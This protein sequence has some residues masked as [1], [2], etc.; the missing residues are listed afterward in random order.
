MH[1]KTRTHTRG[2]GKASNLEE[3][4]S[5]RDP[6]TIGFLF[7]L[8]FVVILL[9]WLTRYLVEKKMEKNFQETLDGILKD[10]I[11][12]YLIVTSIRC[13]HWI[14]ALDNLEYYVNIHAITLGFLLFAISWLV[15]GVYNVFTNHSAVKKW[16]R[17]EAEFAQRF[18]I[19]R[20][21]E[22]LHLEQNRSGGENKEL[23]EY[24]NKLEYFL[25]RQEFISPSFL[26]V[27]GESFLRDD[28]NFSTY[29]AKCLAKSSTL[30]F[31]YTFTSLLITFLLSSI[32][33]AVLL[34]D[35][36]T[37]WMIISMLPI[38]LYFLLYA[39]GFKL[40]QIRAALIHIVDDPYE[41]NFTKFD[42]IR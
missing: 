30:M 41:V 1:T 38:V 25:M 6:A 20:E 16:N 9:I 28:F 10:I 24:K 19:Y 3:F 5:F 4:K 15:L 35:L 2:Y 22:K 40:K 7:G 31:K 39:M 37:Q 29:L 26:P 42:N 12:L 27:L 34:V 36:E 32:F 18:D 17:L 21:Y 8:I 13:L 14:G 33:Y 11:T 23:K